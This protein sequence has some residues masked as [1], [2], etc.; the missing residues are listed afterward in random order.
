MM[1]GNE[2]WKDTRASKPCET[3]GDAS[4]LSLAQELRGLLKSRGLW[5]PDNSAD[6][7]MAIGKALDTNG[8]S[9]G[10]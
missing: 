9:D 3:C 7:I 6:L 10:P 4:R 2:S 1:S 5:C 8:G